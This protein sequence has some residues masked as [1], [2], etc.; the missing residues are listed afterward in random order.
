MS[1]R[2]KADHDAFKEVWL[3][4]EN[5]DRRFPLYP[6][7]STWLSYV[8]TVEG[9]KWGPWWQRAIRLPTQRLSMTLMFPA[10]LEPVV[11]GITTSMTAESSPFPTAI[12]RAQQNDEVVFTWSTDEPPLHARY[13][14]SGS[15]WRRRM[16]R[17]CPFCSQPVNPPLT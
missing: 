3:L 2:V 7:E 15:S 9:H 13:R 17:H 11:W 10:R 5:A 6:G 14:S 1:W 8:Y 4:F 12:A 16:G